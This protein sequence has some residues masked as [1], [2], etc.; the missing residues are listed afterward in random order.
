VS[1]LNGILRSVDSGQ[2]YA[3]RLLRDPA[4]A[5]RLSRTISS[6]EQASSEIQ[7]TAASLN[8]IVTRIDRGPGFAHDVIYGDQPTQAV[9]QFGHAAEIAGNDRHLGL[10]QDDAQVRRIADP[11]AGADRRGERHDRRAAEVRELLADHRIVIGVG[12]DDEALGEQNL[13]RDEQLGVVREEGLRVADHLELD[14]LPASQLARQA[15]RAHRLVGGVA[16]R[17]VGEEEIA[18]LIDLV[19]QRALAQL[20]QV[21]AAKKTVILQEGSGSVA[22]RVFPQPNATNGELARGVFEL[23]AQARWK[24]EELH[25]EEGRLDDVFRSITLSETTQDSRK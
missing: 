23:A 14:P 20:G 17:G 22:A 9:T 16:T 1:S 15:C 3:G 10:L 12:Q 25:T 13:R 2:G 5:E 4:E 18:L 7:K 6:L 11:H 21:P 24:I 19:E 8:R